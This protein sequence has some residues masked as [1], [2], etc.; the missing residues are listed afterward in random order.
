MR[1]ALLTLAF[2]LGAC[3][4][5]AAQPAP[6]PQAPP[7]D[8]I[9]VPHDIHAKND[10]KCIAC[11]EGVYD[12]KQVGT[13]PEALPDE[14]KCLECHKEQKEKGN[15]GFCHTDVKNATK[16]AMLGEGT[17]RMAHDKHIERVK[18]DCTVCHKT[19]PNP[20]ASEKT[21]PTMATCLD[22]HNHSVD[23]AKADCRGC[24]PSLA[25]IALKPVSDFSHQGNY[26]R[27]HASD[28]RSSV[29]NCAQCHDQTFCADCHA[30]RTVSTKIELKFPEAVAAQ[31]IHRN[32]F[33]SRH[34]VEASADPVSCR[35]CH[36]QTFC[37]SCHQ[38]ENLT[39]IAANPRDPHPPGWS[40][41]GTANFHGPAA[42]RDIASCASCHDQGPQ[43]NCV[44]CHRVGGIGGNPHP[45]AWLGHHD[46]SEISKNGMCSACHS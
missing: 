43:S 17:V 3:S 30:A 36:G 7:K 33:V 27:R 21:V 11:H 18:E 45:A 12:E 2:V 25:R 28:A 37:E 35:R 9:R 16:F 34:Q 40:L 20:F 23:Y 22:C 31:F 15:C 24:H 29:E 8:Q 6:E 26:V 38:S 1:R 10:V 13:T 42:R 44:S 41:P 32:D 14:A 39:P 5:Y 46:H 4:R 19:L